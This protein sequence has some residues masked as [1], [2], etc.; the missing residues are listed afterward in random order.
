[1]AHLLQCVVCSQNMAS[2][3]DCCP[4]CGSK[5]RPKCPICDN[6]RKVYYLNEYWREEKFFGWT[7]WRRMSM[8]G[9]ITR[10][11]KDS[12][13]FVGIRNPYKKHQEKIGDLREEI[14]PRCSGSS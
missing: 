8:I 9:P 1:M 11:H 5:E 14:C 2:D 7:E 3:A 6:E 13:N 12:L 10:R 4:H